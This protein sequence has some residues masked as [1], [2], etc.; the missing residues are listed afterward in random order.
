MPYTKVFANIWQC[1]DC[2]AHAEGGSQCIKHHATCKPG[3]SKRWEEFYTKANEEEMLYTNVEEGVWQCDNCGAYGP[4]TDK[5]IHHNI[6][7]PD[8]PQKILLRGAHRAVLTI[9]DVEILDGSINRSV[10]TSDDADAEVK[11]LY[12][13]YKSL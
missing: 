11:R 6:C 13:I 8:G 7:Y 5:V 10:R 2:G 4:T 3:E 12:H 9:S 1:D